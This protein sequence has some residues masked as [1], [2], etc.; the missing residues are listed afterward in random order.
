MNNS[1][2]A[3]LATEKQ[4]PRSKR[5]DGL[6]PVALV[7][8]MNRE[9]KQVL[10][11]ITAK[12]AAIARGIEI[13][14]SSMAKGG[15]LFFFGAGTSGRLGVIEAAECPPTFNTARG[16]IQAVMAGGHSAVF[17][18]KEGAEDSAPAAAKAVRQRVRRGD[19]VVGIAASGITAFV[20][21]ALKTS[22]ALGARTILLTCNP[23]ARGGDLVIA[24]N[25]GAEVLTGST[26]L[27]AGSACKMA[28]NMLTTGSM[29]RLG[30][31]YGQWMVDLQPKSAKLV[32]RGLRLIQSL[33]GVGEPEAKRL[34]RE[35][36]GHVKVAIVMSRR[37]VNRTRAIK[38]L[39]K[40][41]G[42][43]GKLL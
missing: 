1:R 9:D 43:L 35:A 38:E 41:N 6:S 34:F 37:H 36:H 19:V 14:S 15:R 20:A 2:F 17:R 10:Q 11:A 4:N 31:V 30:K 40:V 22:K 28:L 25:T 12:K 5:L 29:V 26:R 13:I 18:S 3:R 32:A 33:A 16:Q 23:E 8:L 39:A 21:S 7:S 24:L 27:K 42:F